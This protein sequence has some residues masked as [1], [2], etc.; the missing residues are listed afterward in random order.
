VSERSF[1]V[2]AR[3]HRTSI[4][5]RV[6]SCAALVA[7]AATTGCSVATYQP[8]SL[9]LDREAEIDDDDIR[10]AFE[11][12][13]QLPARMTVAFY[14]LGTHDERTLGPGGKDADDEPLAGL[15]NDAELEAMLA[16]LPGVDGVYRIPAVAVSGQQ[17]YGGEHGHGYG[18][19]A[20]ELSVKKLRLI[21]ARAHADVLVVFDHGRQAGSVNGLFGFIPLIVPVLF[22]PMFDARVESYMTAYVVDVRNGYFYGQLD[23]SERGGDDYVTIYASDTDTEAALQWGR[24]VPQMS[25]ELAK[26]F[27][28]QRTPVT[29]EP[30]RS[31]TGSPTAE[32]ARAVPP[33]AP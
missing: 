12:K 8:R 13:P 22:V 1:F 7:L 24:L 18:A 4:F 27:V 28:A 20:A 25:G 26:L 11:A 6:V 10:K 29:P 33:L 19:P 21:A 31:P 3:S 9:P 30:P 16:K 14:S 23:A 15:Q 5:R 2:T 17:R 32:V